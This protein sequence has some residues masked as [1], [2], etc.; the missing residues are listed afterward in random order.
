VEVAGVLPL[1]VVLFGVQ[2]H[3]FHGSSLFPRCVFGVSVSSGSTMCTQ[4]YA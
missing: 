2:L 3:A 1:V 4:S